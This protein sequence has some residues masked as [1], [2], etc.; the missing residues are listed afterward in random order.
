MSGSAESPT[1][2]SSAR[3]RCGE[4]RVIGCDPG[5]ITGLA[6]YDEGTLT[7]VAVPF[8]EVAPTL[9]AWLDTSTVTHVAIERYVITRNTAR[10]TQQTDALKV[11]GI[12]ESLVHL[13]GIHTV[14]YQNMSAAKRFGSPTFMRKLGW[15]ATGHHA[16]HMNDAT[17][18]VLELLVTKFPAWVHLHVTPD[19][20]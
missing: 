19:I 18:Q 17:S 2:V 10:K 7:R 16:T 1:P 8:H 5:K 20:I 9:T 4:A 13:S 6:L 14:T 15:W 11:S 3:L 12:I